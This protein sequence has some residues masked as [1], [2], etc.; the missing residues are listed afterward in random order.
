[1]VSCGDFWSKTCDKKGVICPR[2]TDNSD[3][4]S[5]EESQTSDKFQCTSEKQAKNGPSSKW[6]LIIDGFHTDRTVIQV[7]LFDYASY[8]AK[9]LQM[10]QW[11]SKMETIPNYRSQPRD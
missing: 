6:K 7:V 10:Q 3:E 11:L 1:M 4:V 9:D 8:V 2:H 5:D